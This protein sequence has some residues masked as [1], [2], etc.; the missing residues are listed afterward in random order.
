MTDFIF[1]AI[2][3]AIVGAAAWYVYRSKKRGV[4]CI[5]CPAAG[6]CAH[7]CGQASGCGGMSSCGCHTDTE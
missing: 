3:L 6:S 4:K 5:G 7:G 2:L 1:A